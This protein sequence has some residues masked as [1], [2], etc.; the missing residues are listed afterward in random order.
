M[1]KELSVYLSMALL[2]GLVGGFAWLTHH[3][4][5]PWLETAGDWPVVGP[6]TGPLAERFRE[7]YLPPPGSEP[8]EIPL[9]DVIYVDED[10]NPIDGPLKIEPGPIRRRAPSAE[11]SRKESG[12]KQLPE[13]GRVRRTTEPLARE[14]E[15]PE[16]LSPK[17]L[18]EPTSAP[19]VAGAWRWF[20][21]GQPVRIEPDRAARPFDH[22]EAM[23]YLPVVETNGFWTQV[24]YGGEI[25][26]V[27][28]TWEPDHD[29]RA[30]RAK[31]PMST[32]GLYQVRRKFLQQVRKIMGEA[33]TERELGDYTLY[34][35][36]RD[37]ALLDLL[38]G[39]VSG[40]EDAYYARYARLPAGD[41]G[42]A[43]VLFAERSDYLVLP[44]SQRAWAAGHA[45]PGTA[46]SF[47]SGRSHAAVVRTIVHE[48]GHLLNRRALGAGVPTWI[49]EGLASDLGG[50]W[51]EDADAVVDPT[52][53]AWPSGDESLETF[54]S[55]GMDAAILAMAGVSKSGV[56]AS[57]ELLL[58]RSEAFYAGSNRSYAYAHAAT[59]VRFL[60]EGESKA[61][62]A[63][64]LSYLGRSSAGQLATPELLAR[65]IGIELDELDRRYSRWLRAEEKE[66][67]QRYR[68]HWKELLRSR[69]PAP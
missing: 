40:V 62:R 11:G 39:A 3:P 13:A 22:L 66:I 30:A 33:M 17:P 38:A 7:V 18:S 49:E 29:P 10:G 59:L 67:R 53:F 34:T 9:V 26:W 48:L 23:A 14:V 21:P 25:G 46:V 24:V 56:P 41:G 47:A 42:S 31:N 2:V 68:R 20:S 35:D 19:F 63:G 45:E 36:V 69:R 61:L 28:S 8:P 65:E 50:V 52:R 37:E 54:T 64:F 32:R 5:T 58:L 43:I 55:H 15:A 44:S 1:W 4:E 60:I 51:M 16:I 12:R 6:V 27:D 57:E